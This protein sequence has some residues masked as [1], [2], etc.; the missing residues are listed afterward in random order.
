MAY[1]HNEVIIKTR[2]P[3][4]SVTNKQHNAFSTKFSINVNLTDSADQGQ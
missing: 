3:N 1:M 2:F 4:Y